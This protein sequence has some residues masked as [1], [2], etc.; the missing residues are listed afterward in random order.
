MG[1]GDAEAGLRALAHELGL[2]EFVRFTGWAELD[3][4]R[5][6]LSTSDVCVDTMPKTPYSDAA[7]MN[8]ILEYMSVGRP[9][10]AFDLVE[11]RVSAGEAAV[12][13]RPDDVRDLA[14]H[15]LAL[16]ADPE[17]RASMGRFGRERIE[18]ELAWEHQKRYLLAAY[19]ELAARKGR[20]PIRHDISP[21]PEDE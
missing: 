16:L 13:A 7:T 5:G 15:I 10:A 8:K 14:D 4:I 18:N 1:F 12:F 9:I 11:S 17:R 20:R 19:D 6:T 3:L 2:N 21:R